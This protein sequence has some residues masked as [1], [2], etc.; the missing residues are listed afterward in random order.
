MPKIAN[1]NN[2]PHKKK[3]SSSS[4]FII[5]L[6]LIIFFFIFFSDFNSSNVKQ[7]SYS[8]FVSYADGLYK[9][10]AAQSKDNVP[11]MDNISVIAQLTDRSAES[12]SYRILN[13]NKTIIINKDNVQKYKIS[14]Y[15]KI[16]KINVNGKDNVDGIFIDENGTNYHFVTSIP[17]NS[18][19][20]D[21]LAKRDIEVKVSPIEKSSGI[22]NS[23][24]GLLPWILMIF[25]IWFFFIRQVSNSN[26]KAFSF[27]KSRARLYESGK[28]EKITFNDVAGCEEVKKELF[29]VIDFLRTP[30]KYLKMGA[31]IPKGILLSGSPGTGKTL[32][33]RA[34]AGE[35]N[36]PFFS[37]SASEF[38]EMFVGVGASRVRDLFS[39]AKKNSPCIIFID[40]LDSI[41]RMRGIGTGGG[42]DEK[43]QTL[44]QILS[45]MDGFEKE[46][47]I[48]VLAATNRPDILDPALL[49]PGRFDRQIHIDIP[50][51]TDR[52]AI[53]KLHAKN[54]PISPL[55][56]F[57]ELAKDISGF[58][59]A[60]IANLI[61][62]SILIAT[63]KNRKEVTTEDFKEA[64]AKVTRQ[65]NN[66]STEPPTLFGRNRAKFFE[67]GNKQN[68]TFKD[69]AGAY[70][71]KEE[72]VEVVDFLKNPERYT[73][74]GARI[75]KGILLSG[76]PGTGKTLL[77]KAV[78]GEADRP[79]FSASGSDFVEMF[80]GVGA[81]R[82]RDLFS[83]AKKNAPCIVFIDEIDAVG[84]KRGSN[85][86]GGND[87]RDQTLNQILVEMDGFNSSDTVIVLASTNMADILDPA[88]L[89]PGRFDRQ[90]N[91]EKPD[92]KAREEILQ[93]HAKNKPIDNS[94]N[95][96]TI[97][98]GTV[99]FSGADLENLLNEAALLA[100][101]DHKTIIYENDIEN[102]KDKVLMGPEKRNLIMLQKEKENTA[103]HESGHVIV[104]HYLKETDP[105]Y[106]VTIVPRGF[107]LGVT[108]Q[109]PID[110]KKGYSKRFILNRIAILMAGRIAEEIRFGE[111]AITTG[112]SN[113]IKVATEMAQSYVTKFGMSH[114]IGHVAYD[115]SYNRNT[116]FSEEIAKEI[117]QEVK[118]IIEEQYNVA[119]NLLEKHKKSL[120]KMSAL[121]LEQETLD[122]KEV[123]ALLG[124]K[125]GVVALQA[126]VDAEYEKFFK[127]KNLKNNSEPTEE[128]IENN[129]I[130]VAEQGK[131][132][133]RGSK[134]KEE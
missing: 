24:I 99:G 74:L 112:A 49:R 42:N 109:I 95:L 113:D 54:K 77:A 6:G 87:E 120:E 20:I 39:L 75:P 86:G 132:K 59:G 69:V 41:G 79:F 119:K 102:A 101:R 28:A 97:A 98:K 89:R 1:K 53:L 111:D 33:A 45:E 9:I 12:S 91:I 5:F 35:A 62:E 38:V 133:K 108:Q 65:K 19:I 18:F 84:K 55:V 22:F 92:V 94:V 21:D 51:E 76:P 81:S 46:S 88:L 128:N 26:N 72:L 34:V 78:A 104:A 67:K 117:D 56:N 52:V 85:F 66:T 17:Q 37:I 105:V 64:Q 13:S 90:I 27:G 96:R 116:S 50:N 4:I 118:N 63:R 7:L 126:E 93:V 68:L 25:F 129:P 32:L 131:P 60:E 124:E 14:I 11:S 48:I 106:K 107:A 114:K 100:A 30:E 73:K 36:R 110:D 134:K 71:A 16:L 31:K 44:N 10:D 29:E 2:N 127:R 103:F 130:P 61:N 82:V 115:L 57:E 8:E 125:E 83:N 123:E 43:E 58:S 80:V 3:S 70:E 121:L 47:T 23:L 15:R 40:E 122:S